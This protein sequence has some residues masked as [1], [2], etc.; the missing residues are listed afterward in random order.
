MTPPR[1]YWYIEHAAARVWAAPNDR[2]DRRR[3][4]T[5]PEDA[6]AH[7]AAIR[8][9]E[10]SHTELRGVWTTVGYELDLVWEPVDPDSLPLRDDDAERYAALETYSFT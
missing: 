2:V 7:V 10:P 3:S 4:F 9:W 6:A 1:R 8:R 5:R